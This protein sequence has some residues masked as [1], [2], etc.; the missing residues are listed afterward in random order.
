MN[1]KQLFSTLSLT[2]LIVNCET[3]QANTTVSQNRINERKVRNMQLLKEI[4]KRTERDLKKFGIAKV[5]LSNNG[6]W[7]YVGSEYFRF[8]H[9]GRVEFL[10]Y[11]ETQLQG[12]SYF[13][14]IS[15]NKLFMSLANTPQDY[16][17]VTVVATEPGYYDPNGLEKHKYSISIKSKNNE[18]DLLLNLII[19]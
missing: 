17:Q 12:V 9:N 4:K 19:R 15:D 13:W 2:L 6:T 8:T 7:E 16:L 3:T 1:I 11:G 18:I 10:H 14:K 5:L